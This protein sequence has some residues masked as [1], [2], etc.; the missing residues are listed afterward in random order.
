MR[1]AFVVY[2]VN[3][4]RLGARHVPIFAR[5]IDTCFTGYRGNGC[6][7]RSRVVTM[8]IRGRAR[9]A[10]LVLAL[11]LLLPAAANAQ[12]AYIT[13]R[14]SNTVS[15]IATATNT[16]VATI[17]V[18][19]TPTGVAVTP[20]GAK[21]YVANTSSGTVSVI[22]T[23]S[24]TITTVDSD[25]KCNTHKCSGSPGKGMIFLPT[26]PPS[27]AHRTLLFNFHH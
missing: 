11:A 2:L 4:N 18:G 26:S 17:P 14:G 22:D 10:A 5:R 3:R 27:D 20:D 21:V 12:N 16:V 23:A 25:A 8:P 13:N 19:G 6:R 9:W 24:N 15:V 1:A 7:L